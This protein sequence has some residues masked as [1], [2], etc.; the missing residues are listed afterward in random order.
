[1]NILILDDKFDSIGPIDAFESFIWTDRYC[2]AG[3][4]E[5]YT[6]VDLTMLD[7]AKQDYYI[8]TSESEHLM[9]IDEVIITSDVESG[10]HFTIRGESLEAILGRRIIWQQ[11]ILSGS[12]QDGIQQLLNDNII[13]P[14]DPDRRMDNFIF[15]PS[16]DPAITSLTLAAQ[17]TGRNLY[18]VVKQLCDE[19]GLGFKIVLN[20]NDQFVFSLYCGVDRSYAQ[21]NN[22]YVIFAPYFEN[23][24][25]SNYLETNR[26]L[27]TVALVAG[28][29]EGIDRRTTTVGGGNG[30]AR[31]ELY[32]D[33]RDIQSRTDDGTLD[34]PSYYA[35]LTQR[36]NERLN[37]LRFVKTF[38]GDV[39]TT[40]MFVYG[41]DFFMGDIVQLANEWGIEASARIMEVII[42]HDRSGIS[43][44]PTFS[45]IE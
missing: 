11:T 28:E 35:L 1:M 39:D 30:L 19:R 15:E 21:E 8:W 43:I 38:E 20:D 6:L 24:I 7:N 12:F 2:G 3:D 4:F 25:N 16:V 29:G 45:I 5:V 42:S 23:I 10:N 36:G 41:R 13:N 26:V 37:E 40:S 18:D 17:F 34:D 32:V 33:A 14:T 22:P 9:I 44:V 27:K 31:R